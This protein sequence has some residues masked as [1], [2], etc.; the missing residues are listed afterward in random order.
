[1]S[2]RGVSPALFPLLGV[3]PIKGRVF[4]QE[5]GAQGRDDVLSSARDL[6]SVAS[7]RCHHR[8]KQDLIERR[9]HISRGI[10]RGNSIF[11]CRYSTSRD[12]ASPVARDI[13]KRLRLPTRLS[14]RY[15]RSYGVIDG[16][17]RGF[18]RPSSSSNRHYHDT[19]DRRIQKI[20]RRTHEF[21]AKLYHCRTGRRPDCGRVCGFCS[22]RDARFADR[23]RKSHHYATRPRRIE[24]ARNGNSRRPGRELK[25]MLRQLLTE[26]VLV[27]ILGGTAGLLLAIW[28]ST[29]CG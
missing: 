17:A 11:R 18:Q 24:R 14:A 25:R 8:C 21:G 28:G 16:C 29:C 26:S 13:W 5:E 20:I 22:A 9:P 12:R 7:L 23:V 2:R 19:L 15:S 10:S 27:S 1:V 4:T 6:W 3:E